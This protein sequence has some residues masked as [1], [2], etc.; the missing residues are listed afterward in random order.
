MVML[1]PSLLGLICQ[2]VLEIPGRIQTLLRAQLK[3]VG[4]LVNTMWE[5]FGYKDG[6]GYLKRSRIFFTVH[7][8][9]RVSPVQV[10]KGLVFPQAQCYSRAPSLSLSEG[11]EELILVRG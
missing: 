1:V 2:A 7:C 5:S 8:G 10:I 9:S 6:S 11:R 4:I 3:S